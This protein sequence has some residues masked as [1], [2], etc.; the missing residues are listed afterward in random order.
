MLYARENDR[1]VSTLE[2]LTAP[3]KI[4]K[5]LKEHD[6][7]KRMIFQGRGQRV[8][9]LFDQDNLPRKEAA[10]RNKIKK[11]KLWMR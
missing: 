4:K 9:D 3:N 10:I 6:A 7:F 5:V 8:R 11:N 2:T 1:V